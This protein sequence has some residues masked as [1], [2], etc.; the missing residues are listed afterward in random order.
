MRMHS[1]RA[2]PAA[3]AY[4][5][6]FFSSALTTFLCRASFATR[7]VITALATQTGDGWFATFFAWPGVALN[8]WVL[9]YVLTYGLYSFVMVAQHV[10][11][12]SKN[13]TTNEAINRW[14]CVRCAP[15]PPSLSTFP[16]LPLAL[17]L[18][19]ASHRC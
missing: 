4:N 7:S 14:R 17:S 18:R 19:V 10:M 15:T 5:R 1:L 3:R 8:L 16:P 13:T 12:I 2:R 9:H 11:L 6:R